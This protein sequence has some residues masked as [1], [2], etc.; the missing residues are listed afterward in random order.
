LHRDYKAFSGHPAHQVRRFHSG[1]TDKARWLTGGL[2]LLFLPRGKLLTL[3]FGLT[4]LGAADLTGETS[5]AAHR[6]SNLL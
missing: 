4:F 6:C 2:F 5:L 3:L 1:R